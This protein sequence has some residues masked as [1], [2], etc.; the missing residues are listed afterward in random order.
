M[1]IEAQ[2]CVVGWFKMLTYYLYAQLFRHL[3]PCPEPQSTIFKTGFRSGSK[4]PSSSQR[5]CCPANRCLNSSR[6]DAP[7]IYMGGGLVYIRMLK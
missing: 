2:G 3:T 1:R 5:R 7:N 6:Q 4:T